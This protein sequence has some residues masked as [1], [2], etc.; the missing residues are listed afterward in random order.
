MDPVLAYAILGLALIAVGI[1][2][3]VNNNRKKSRCTA[4]V[5]ATIIRVDWERS[6]DENAGTSQMYNYMPVYG[7]SVNGRNYTW[8]GVYSKNKNQYHVGDVAQL[9]YNPQKPFEAATDSS[10]RGTI[11][12]G[13]FLI[14]AGIA[15]LSLGLIAD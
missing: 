5:P 13:I 10:K 8:K 7:Y 15:F 1:I 3:I 2:A 12:I 11:K 14:I 4:C 6:D 9:W